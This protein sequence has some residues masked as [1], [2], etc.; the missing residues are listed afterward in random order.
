[1]RG[2]STTMT[3]AHTWLHKADTTYSRA[4]SKNQHFSILSF[5]NLH[6]T[7]GCLRVD[8]PQCSNLYQRHKLPWQPWRHV[9]FQRHGALPRGQPIVFEPA[10][11]GCHGWP[12]LLWAVQQPS[13]PLWLW[14]SASMQGPRPRAVLCVCVPLWTIQWLSPEVCHVSRFPWICLVQCVWNI[15]PLPPERRSDIAWLKIEFSSFSVC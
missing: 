3:T 5:S 1:M 7:H 4:R 2:S 15:Y 14:I 6:H 8:R 11:R 9:Q 12:G 13:V 10:Q